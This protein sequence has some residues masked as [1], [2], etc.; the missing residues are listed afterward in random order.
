MPEIPS[1]RI[2]IAVVEWQGKFL[3]GVRPEG[4]PLAGFAEFPGGKCH[5][6][7]SPS[8]CAQRECL[9]ETGLR[10][11]TSVLLLAVSH[12]YPHAHLE[13][14]FWLCTVL[15]PVP[16]PSGGFYWASLAEVVCL[17]FP[18]A[19]KGIVEILKQRMP[20]SK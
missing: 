3:V 13:L 1:T 12:E 8:Q 15:E 5:R 7:E 6:G 17:E 2:G 20:A 18:P 19:N 4:V 10:V 9:E 16:A 11:S 14:N